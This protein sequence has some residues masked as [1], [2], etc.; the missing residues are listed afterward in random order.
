M[1]TPI[2]HGMNDTVP[3]ALPAQV[4]ASFWWELL[5]TLYDGIYVVDRQGLITSWNRGAEDMTGYAAADVLGTRS[6][7]SIMLHTTHDG[8]D[9]VGHGPSIIAQTLRDG[10]RREAECSLRHKEGHWVRV[11]ARAMAI[12]RKRR[13]IIGA[14]LVFTDNLTVVAMKQR[15]RELRHLALSDPLTELGNRRYGEMSL[16]V[17]L[18]EMRRYGWPFG[19]LFI[20]LDGFKSVN[21]TF[22]HEVGDRALRMVAKTLSHNVR[23]FDVVCRWGGEEFLAIIANIHPP[24][25]ERL[26]E[27][28]RSLIQRSSFFSGLRHV[29][30]TVSVGGTTAHIN[31]TELKIVERADKMMYQ[32]K[33][34]G[35]NVVLVE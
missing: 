5:D 17:R 34:Q 21:D 25:L 28:L 30:V 14:A 19:V 23:P 18:D 2:L 6:E 8:D 15:L 29:R 3:S 31:D 10:R 9:N 24:Q 11:L 12:P 33:R 13:E 35:K 7:D 27:K 20:D 26:G 22:G 4:A 1:T 16:R 32:A